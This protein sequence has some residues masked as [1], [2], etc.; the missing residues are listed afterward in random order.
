MNEAWVV[1]FSLIMAR[2]GAFLVV[3]PIFGGQ[4]LPRLVKVGFSMSLGAFWVATL[5]DDYVN[6][7]AT[8]GIELS[9]VQYAI[10]M[11]REGFSGALL[12]FA[13]GLLLLPAR[14]AGSYIGQELGL[15]MATLTD[16]SMQGSSSVFAQIF[17]GLAILLFFALNLHHAIIGTLHASFLR[18]PIGSPIEFDRALRPWQAFSEAHEW[19]LLVAAPAG[20]CL[21][22][23]LI[24]LML[25]MKTAP[26]LNLFSVGMTVRLIAGAITVF[27]FLP[28][29]GLLIIHALRHA[30]GIV[31]RFF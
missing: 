31:H 30:D 4:N 13:M 20:V 25:M 29:M 18:W 24:V 27:A 6:A 12:G 9:W 7:F 17:E 23:T 11:S 15:T 5:G 8:K 10:W 22:L 16:P 3:F 21:F 28:E 14:I 19:G 2:V 1:A 26:Q